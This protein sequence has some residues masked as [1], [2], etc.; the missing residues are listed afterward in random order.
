[1]ISPWYQRAGHRQHRPDLPTIPSESLFVPF[2]LLNVTM[3]DTNFI[4]V[5]RGSERLL[6]G[7]LT[8]T[9]LFS[10]TI[11]FRLGAIL[12][13][14]ATSSSSIL[15]RSCCRPVSDRG[16]GGFVYRRGRAPR[17]SP[18]KT[19]PNQM[20]EHGPTRTSPTRVAV[21]AIKAVGAIQPARSSGLPR[22][23]TA[24]ASMSG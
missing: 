18:R 2:A 4:S 15:R 10:F 9:L 14:G 7:G 20:L 24:D 6:R 19:A 1:M 11:Q 3:E 22:W 5:M 16:R 23:G 12:S 21:C 8:K 13:H 17:T